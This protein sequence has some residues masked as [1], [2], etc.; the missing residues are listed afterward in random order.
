LWTRTF[1]IVRISVVKDRPSDVD[2]GWVL[3]GVVSAN[4]STELDDSEKIVARS[5]AV[6]VMEEIVSLEAGMKWLIV[7]V[8]QNYRK[9][10]AGSRGSSLNSLSIR[11]RNQ[12]A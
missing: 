6:F 4:I 11:G 7:E 8:Y 2:T 9:C 12:G 3:T 5:D 10:D 1:D